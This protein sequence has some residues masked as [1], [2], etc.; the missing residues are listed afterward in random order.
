MRPILR[1]DAGD[2]FL[3]GVPKVFRPAANQSL[4]IATVGD[5]V[6]PVIPVKN[7][8]AARLGQHV[9]PFLPVPDLLLGLLPFRD[10]LHRAQHL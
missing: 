5:L 6:R 8:L 2:P 4:G 3:N 1:M 9:V 7:D 10:I